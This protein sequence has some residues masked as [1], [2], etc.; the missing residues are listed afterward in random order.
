M[1]YCAILLKQAIGLLAPVTPNISI[2]RRYLKIIFHPSRILLC[3][4]LINSIKE[5]SS[6]TSIYGCFVKHYSV[7]YIVALKWKHSYNTIL[8][9]W[10]V[11]KTK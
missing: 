3:F 9:C 11:F 2:G 10:A 6:K 7:F 5:R 4:C 1:H 8:S